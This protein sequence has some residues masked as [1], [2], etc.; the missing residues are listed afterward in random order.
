MTKRLS[1]ILL[2][3][4]IVVIVI[5][6]VCNWEDFENIKQIERKYFLHQSI[7]AGLILCV[8]GYVNKIFL[9]LFNIKL[10]PKEW[11]GLAVLNALGNYITPFRGGMAFKGIYLRKKFN[12]P[13]STFA[14]TVAANYILVFLSSGLLGIITVI[15]IFLLH[16]K[17]QWKLFAFFSAVILTMIG[18]IVFSPTIE[19]PQNRLTRIL[20]S[21][22]DG[23]K[24]IRKNK[25]FL[26]KI[27]AL[28]ILNFFIS[29]FQLYYG[30]KMLSI[31]VAILPIFLMSLLMSFAILIAITPANIGIQ[32]AA[33]GFISEIMGIGF[34]E[35]IMVAGILRVV[36]MVI[37]F[38]LGP[39]FIYILLKKS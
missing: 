37:V 36:S 19:E 32:E 18:I 25:I 12:F 35:G 4:L 24:K 33:V 29:C 15:L 27:T 5:Y 30:Y 20:K 17:M 38:T 21:I 22:L 13:Y 1:I 34:N 8:N 9:K 7:L 10:V 14:S 28:L 3:I 39:I 2:L 16:G 23:W 11:F 26:T 31:E 6:V